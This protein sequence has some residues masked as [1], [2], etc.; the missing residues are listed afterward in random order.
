MLIKKNN[1]TTISIPGA[2][3]LVGIVGGVWA[4]LVV[5]TATLAYLPKHPDFSIFTTYL[6]DIG[7]TPVWPQVLFNSGTL[8]AAPLRYFIV[9]L[10]VLRLAQLGAGRAFAT[11]VLIIAFI[12][13]IGT[14][15]MTAVPFSKAPAI[16]KL[17]IPLYFFGV[18]IFQMI[19]FFKEWGLKNVPRIL[20]LLS[21]LLVI[22]FFIF[23]A[24]VVLL[25]K[26][27]VSRST[28]V[29]WEWLAFFTSVVWV[30]A[31]SI[32]L[33]KPINNK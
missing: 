15:L 29:I 12:S 21:L 17:G 2:L 7:D 4:I 11:S 25:E 32:L 13:V 24:M 23:V 20:P 28:P 9:A 5:L 19:I 14:I 8:I 6:S 1:E 33:G 3:K 26:G 10:L 31:Q 30:F 27:V 16:H 18:V 22:V